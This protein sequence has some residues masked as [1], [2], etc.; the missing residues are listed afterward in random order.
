M[1]SAPDEL[2]AA[3]DAQL[4][5]E[6]EMSGARTWHRHGPLV[7]GLFG[8]GGFVSY[9]NLGDLAVDAVDRLISETV[10]WFRD[11]TE[12]ASFEWKTR[13]HDQPADLPDRLVGHGFRPEPTETV[14]V[15]PAGPLARS[16]DLAVDLL[17]GVTVRRAGDHGDLLD[18]VTRAARL[19]AE[20]FGRGSG[21]TPAELAA[22]LAATPELS[23]LWLAE[24]PDGAVVGAG[25]LE[26]AAGTDFAGLWGGA[27]QG[28]WRGRGI[29][30]ALVAARARA[31]LA[32]GSALLHSDCTELSRPILERSGLVA[33][34]TTT[35]YL[36]TRG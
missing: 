23:S 35:P 7:R 4:R 6:A 32:A 9:R 33:V 11:H 36:W 12:V 20:V 30:R 8:R 3:Y 17:E 24:V 15:G 5:L 19:Q 25:R 16:V 31:A 13:G 34:T 22:R 27:T 21:P 14:M 29:Y 2:R 1:T 26:I 18:D 10:A 28:P